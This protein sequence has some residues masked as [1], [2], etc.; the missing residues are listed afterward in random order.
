MFVLHFPA[1]CRWM[2]FHSLFFF[3]H[4][5]FTLSSIPLPMV[6]M[7]QPWMSCHVR[8]N[9]VVREAKLYFSVK[10]VF[11]SCQQTRM[12]H[13][14]LDS[15]C[16]QF[17]LLS[18]PLSFPLCLLSLAVQ[19]TD[20][21]YYFTWTEFFCHAVIVKVPPCAQDKSKHFSTA[22]VYALST[23]STSLTATFHTFFSPFLPEDCWQQIAFLRQSPLLGG[24]CISCAPHYKFNRYCAPS[25]LS[26]KRREGG[27]RS[28]W[29][30]GHAPKQCFCLN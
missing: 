29:Q 16:S 9:S 18:R 25:W 23:F 3:K 26:D 5:L 19:R 8:G 10:D 21:G 30:D 11:S 12:H 13:T 1:E 6:W 22:A 2:Q 7:S 17:P 15:P 20:W 27:W 28:L 4:L 14:L 24:I